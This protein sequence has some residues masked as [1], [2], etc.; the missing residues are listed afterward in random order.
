MKTCERSC[1]I[2][3][4][5]RELEFPSGFCRYEPM[6]DSESNADFYGRKCSAEHIVDSKL[7]EWRSRISTSLEDTS[8]DKSRASQ[9]IYDHLADISKTGFAF[10]DGAVTQCFGI[11]SLRLTELDPSTGRVKSVKYLNV[12]D[13]AS[14]SEREKLVPSPAARGKL[15]L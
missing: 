11:D 9:S 13:L 12:E 1:W 10:I 2:R 15:E 14:G 8:V 6:L 4:P 5:H 7:S 3:S